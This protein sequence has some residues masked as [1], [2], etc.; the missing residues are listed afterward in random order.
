MTKNIGGVGEGD[1][2]LEQDFLTPILLASSV[3]ADL[4]I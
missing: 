2:T 1:Y 3:G 4:W